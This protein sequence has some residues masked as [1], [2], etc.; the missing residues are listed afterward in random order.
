MPSVLAL[1]TTSTATS[2]CA[3]RASRQPARRSAACQATTTAVLRGAAHAPHAG[4]PAA[5]P[6]AAG[7]RVAG[8]GAPHPHRRRPDLRRASPPGPPTAAGC[9]CCTASRRAAREWEPLLAVLADAGSARGRAGPARLL[10]RAPARSASTP[11]GCRAWSPTSSGMLDALGWDRADLV[12]HDWGAAVALADRGRGAGS[13]CAPW[14]RSRC[15][16]RSRSPSRCTPTPSSGRPRRTCCGS[17]SR[18]RRRRQWLLADDAAGLRAFFAGSD[19]AEDLVEHYLAAMQQPG[20]LTAGLNWYRAA[21]ADDVVAMGRV[22]C[23]TTYVWSTGDAALRSAPGAR[24]RGP[25]RGAVHLRRARRGEPL[26]A[27][28]GPGRA[29]RGRAGAP[30]PL[31][32]GPPGAAPAPGPARRADAPGCARSPPAGPGT[33]T[34]TPRR[35]SATTPVATWSCCWSQGV[36]DGPE[37]KGLA[38]RLTGPRRWVFRFPR[39][40]RWPPGWR[41]RRACCLPRRP[42]AGAAAPGGGARADARRRDP[43]HRRGRPAR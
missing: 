10:P 31:V 41:S 8:R 34:S 21:H 14:S 16:T 18:S 26:G 2:G 25:R 20:A 43:V 24:D 39:R 9:C 38:R 4:R 30:G 32:T 7:V 27:R 17:G 5:A 19:L 35:P 13:G 23:P 36:W 33:S 42:A 3:S 37:P 15:R 1:S 6:A 40:P 22:T 29:R 28:G 12:G 11:T